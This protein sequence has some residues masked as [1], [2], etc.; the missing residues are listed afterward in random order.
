VMISSTGKTFSFTGWKVG[1]TCA[2]AALTK[3]VRS[4]HQF[5]TFCSGAPYQLAMA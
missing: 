1:Y 5:L 2:S 3:A 4:T